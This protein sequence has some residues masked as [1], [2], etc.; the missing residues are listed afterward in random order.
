MEDRFLFRGKRVDNGEWVIGGLV[1]GEYLDERC[2]IS[3]IKNS[4]FFYYIDDELNLIDYFTEVDPE[5]ICQCTG[6][7]DKNGKLIFEGDVDSHNRIIAWNK[8]ALKAIDNNGIP[9]P[10]DL[11]LEITG[12]IHEEE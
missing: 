4:E 1:F 5:T 2:F 6:L 3:D 8:D 7:R 9:F 10:I 11:R 12:N